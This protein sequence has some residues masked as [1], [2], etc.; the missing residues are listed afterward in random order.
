MKRKDMVDYLLK[1]EEICKVGLK[2]SKDP[3]AVDNY[4]TLQKLTSEFINE[5]EEVEMSR[6]NF[7][8][9]DVYPT[10]NV[11]VR[12]IIFDET[13]TRV[14]M[15]Q[16]KDDGGWSFPGGWAEIGLD[17]S[18]SAI[19]ENREEAGVEVE[20]VRVV[21]VTNRCKNVTEPRTPEYIITFEGKIVRKL[22]DP[23]YEI[24]AMDYFPY[25]KLPPLSVKHE[26]VQMEALA[27]AAHDNKVIFD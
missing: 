20:I 26:R 22:S 23:C 4:A 16:E 14:L 1:V 3:Y 11:S 12:T 5:K 6:P 21:G 25:D 8:S 24:I 17:P 19:K 13:R 7:F 18:E 10:P 15:V 9:R 2:Y 27:I